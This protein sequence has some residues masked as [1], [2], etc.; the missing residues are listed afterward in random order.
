MHVGPPKPILPKLAPI[1]LVFIDTKE[2]K[3][4][5]SLSLLIFFFRT[6][7]SLEKRYYLSDVSRR[8]C[9]DKRS[10]GKLFSCDFYTPPVRFLPFQ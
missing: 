6:E 8:G 7:I 4:S 3:R 1:L 2:I 9:L 10:N 5:L